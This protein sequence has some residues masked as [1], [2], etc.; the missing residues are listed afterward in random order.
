MLSSSP[1]ILQF[2]TL[3]CSLDCRSSIVVVHARLC[4][5]VCVCVFKWDDR[6]TQA[7]GIQSTWLA[8]RGGWPVSRAMRFASKLQTT[9][10]NRNTHTNTHRHAYIRH[11]DCT[12]HFSTTT[13]TTT[14]R[15]QR[16]MW[17]AHIA[18]EFFSLGAAT[19]RR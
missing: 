3:L 5:S 1:A 14:T 13:I 19:E 18:K 12:L 11:R 9:D 6:C 15:R 4:L 16:Q 8:V 7:K 17:C 10:T 2:A